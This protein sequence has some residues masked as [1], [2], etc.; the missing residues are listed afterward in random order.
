VATILIVD[1]ERINRELLH[2][3]FDGSPHELIDADSGEAALHTALAVRPDLV[4]LDVMMPGLDGFATT[5]RLKT[6]FADELLP[7]ILVTAMHDHESRIRGLRAG[8]DDF[9]TKPVEQ[10]ELALRVQNLLALRAKEAALVRR[11]VELVELQRFRDEMSALVVHD[12]KNPLSVILANIDYVID[13]VGDEQQHREA[14]LDAKSAGARALRLLANL[15]DMTRIEAGQLPLDRHPMQVAALL[16][17]LVKQRTRLAQSRAIVLDSTIDPELPVF[18]DAELISRVVENVFDNALRHTPPG[19]RIAVRGVAQP[20][21]VQIRIGN[22]GRPIPFDARTRIF[23][24]F[25]QGTAQAG[26][27]NLGLGLYFCR[28][29]A[30]AHGGK[31]WV[32]ETRDLPTVFNLELPRATD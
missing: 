24:K 31:I 1:D 2:A 27:M 12:L 17:P 16:A 18:V 19:G 9:V 25:A 10:H 15:A 30:E 29:A 20:D 11:N 6:L 21:A 22:T 26:R 4:L 13:G 23:E 28:L 5:K 3:Y 14:L 32:E 7:V 8:A